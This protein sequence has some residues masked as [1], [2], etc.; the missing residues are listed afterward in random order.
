MTDNS[1]HYSFSELASRRL[2]EVALAHP[3]GYYEGLDTAGTIVGVQVGT[4]HDPGNLIDGIALAGGQSGMNY[5]FGEL[6]AR[7]TISGVVFVDNNGNGTLKPNNTLLPGVTVYLLDSSGNQI[8]S[9]T[10]DANGKYA[11]TDLLPGTYGTATSAVRLSARKNNL[12]SVTLSGPNKILGAQLA[13]AGRHNYDFYVVP[14]ATIS[15]YVFPKARRW[16]W[17]AGRCRT[18][19]GPRRAAHLR[20]HAAFGRGDAVVRRHRLPAVGTPRATPSPP[21]PT[22]TATTN[23]PICPGQYSVVEQQPTSYT[24]YGT[25]RAAKAGWW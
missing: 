18:S 12:A 14:P 23:S 15:G 3:A 10:T 24:Q 6:Q 11:F 9:T 1:G 13:S 25:R 21:R 8:T 5:N 19:L 17:R 2:H 4:A 22:P 16:C 20:R 7:A